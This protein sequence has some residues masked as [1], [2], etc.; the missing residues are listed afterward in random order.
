ME[1][2]LREVRNKLLKEKLL[3]GDTVCYRSSGWS[4]YPR[5]SCGDMTTYRPVR[6]ADEVLVGDIVLCEVQPR[7][8]FYAHL[9]SIKKWGDWEEKWE[10][11]ISNI[12]GYENGWCYIEHIHGVLIDVEA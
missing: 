9:V 11:R 5:V 4:L 6:S 1:Y 3:S 10:F 7:S 8:R 12:N 2:R